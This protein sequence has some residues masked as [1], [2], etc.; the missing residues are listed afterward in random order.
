MLLI[1]GLALVGA[2][3]LCVWF[4][5][6]RPWRALNVFFNPRTSWMTRE[7]IVGTVLMPVGLAAAAGVPGLSWLAAG[8]ALAFI[9]C[10]ARILKA[11]KG[12]PCWREPLIVPLV[13]LTGRAEGGGLWLLAQP[14]Q[15][16]RQP[17]L[18]VLVGMLILARVLVWLAYRRRLHRRTTIQASTALD[19]AGRWLQVAGTLI[20]LV[21]LTLAAGVL[22]TGAVAGSSLALAGL[23]AVGTG[24]W[25]KFTV[26]TRA[27]FNQGFGLTYLPVRGARQ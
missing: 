17:I 14:M 11:A 10:Q 16:S 8:L 26:I 21:I 3:L 7:G 19:L 20:P 22:T 4:E 18:I 27:G 2:G 15:A 25:L 9:Y 1:G 6:G 13:V 12:I 24:A 23:L 5:I